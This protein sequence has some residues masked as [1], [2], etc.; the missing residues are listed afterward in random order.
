MNV[1]LLSL[2]TLRADR[3]GCYGYG[4][5]TSPNLDRL[6]AEGVVFE[7]CVSPHIPTHPAH[8][9]LFTG[10]DVWR[11]RVL[12]QGGSVDLSPEIPT[13][14]EMLRARGYR[15]AAADNLGRWFSRGF[16]RYEGYSWSMEPGAP[17]RK[18][19]AV[20]E[21]ALRLL[22]DCAAAGRPFFLFLHYWDPHTPYLP[23]PP[24]DRRFYRGDER[25]PGN[26]SMDAVMA[27]PA[28]RAYFRQWLPGV[29]DIEYPKAL[30]DGSVAYLD[31]CLGELFAALER[32]GL[33][34]DTLVVVTA[35]HGEEL[36]EHA[37]WFDHHG[38]YDTNLHIPLILRWPQGLPAGRRVLGQVQIL[39]VA[40]TVLDLAGFPEV[41][42]SQAMVGCSQA[43]A[44]RG[45]EPPEPRPAYLTES[46]WERKRGIRTEQWKLILAL[47]DP[48]GKPPVELY[49]L[50]A[51][52]LERNNLANRYPD[53]VRELTAQLGDHQAARVAETG[54]PDPLETSQI[55]MRHLG[56]EAP[57]PPGQTPKA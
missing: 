37:L 30:Y 34:E 44:A 56:G 33:A 13:L 51:D 5:D 17:W 20:N 28:F 38:L 10:Q 9:S 29:T 36:D 25:A 46:T 16:E 49:D 52:P 24:Y 53:V 55:S 19:E 39:D 45:E 27:E 22:E 47:E 40:P 41:P 57:P 50:A 14:A 18:A 26:R 32:L 7:R 23:P 15:T 2:D 6:A 35:D 8:T 12:Q 3:L 1:L 31:A 43:R 42:S 54:L 11:H 48:F 21:T 4:R